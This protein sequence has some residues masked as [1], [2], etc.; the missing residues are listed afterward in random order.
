MKNKKKVVLAS[1]LAVG[2][3]MSGALMVGCDGNMQL[4]LRVKDNYIQWTDD[5]EHWWN[6]LSLNDLKEQDYSTWTIGDDG[7]W[8]LNGA[9]TDKQAVGL[10]GNGIVSIVVDEA[11]SND[12]KT[13]YVIN[14]DNGTTFSFE[15]AN[16]NDGVSGDLYTIGKDG[17]WYCNGDKTDYK[18]VG[19]D[20]NGITSIVFDE[21]HST[22]TES[23][24]VI[25]YDNGD[26]FTL[27]VQN[28][29]D[30]KDGTT[31]TIE[32]KD[33]YWHINS[34]N[35][36]IAA[37]GPA[38]ETG[39]DGA[40]WITGT[41]VFCDVAAR[42]D[43]I[44]VV[45]D[46]EKVGDLYFN[47]NTSDIFKCTAD[48]TWQWVANI[49]GQQGEQGP[50][51]EQGDAGVGIASVEKN[52]EKST[53]EVTV[54]TITLTDNSTYDFEVVNGAD[55]EQGVQGNTGVG[56]SSIVKNDE[57]SSEEK[58][59]YTI[60]LSDGS[61]YDFEV[62]HGVDATYSTYSISYD[63][64]NTKDFFDNVIESTEIKS[65]EW[66]TNI[67]TVKEEMKEFFLGWFIKD[68]D[69]KIE[70]YDFIGGNVTLEAR[71]QAGLYN[72]E[73]GF[74]SWEKLVADGDIQVSETA[75]TGATDSLTGK[76]FV[77]EGI[78]AINERAFQG[79]SLQ[80][81]ILSSNV[82]SVGAQAFEGCRNLE[83]VVL[84][85]DITSIATELFH[86]CSSLVSVTIPAK[87]QKIDSMAFEACTS[88]KS[89]V[90]PAS[91][92]KI[93]N[94]N[95]FT[96]CTSLESIVVEAG[97]TVFDSRNNCNAIIEGDELRV[98]C[99]NTFIPDGITLISRNAFRGCAGLESIRIPSTVTDIKASAFEGCS[100]LL[101]VKLPS[102]LKTIGSKAFYNC[103]KLLAVIIP[104][105]ITR[106]DAFSFDGSALED[107]LFEGTADE[108]L[109]LS[110]SINTSNDKLNAATV[111]YY[112][113]TEPST[114]GNFWHYSESGSYEI[115]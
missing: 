61:T 93:D 23:H 86:N 49:K 98:G 41:A 66:L 40:T 42:G 80:G 17:Y 73:S 26:S 46:D 112:S 81:A 3:A 74:K 110:S 111:Y 67:P 32:I 45:V 50:Q 70:K 108:W 22:E 105:S 82:T 12:E 106:I 20:G 7:Y 29:V 9:K 92:T 88:L 39:D 78:T 4:D 97:N 65:T 101:V 53:E 85:S 100:E 103:T 52:T 35:T 25:T 11:K 84:P 104:T 60:T 107:V 90:I 91:V 72:E 64:G 57:K 99:K 83:S 36:G 58:F 44:V 54:Y 33:G 114:T 109:A 115:W 8:Y 79:G 102:G 95:P 96:G 77:D 48:N 56:I 68:T 13:T 59:V 69:K 63:Y 75:V 62:E 2:T 5:G 31:P 89:I 47:T 34:K 19:E 21:A 76:L 37:Q 10:P 30:G 43:E 55:G 6:L 27:V 18:A 87:V 14:F 16:G 24:Y 15:V 51:G 71:F 94:Y 113:Q 1:A 28:G 38:G